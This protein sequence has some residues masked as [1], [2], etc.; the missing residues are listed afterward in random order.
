MAKALEPY[1]S[2]LTPLQEAALER[3]EYFTE[4]LRKMGIVPRTAIE[5]EMMVVD[6][7]GEPIPM[8]M[9]LEGIVDAKNK[10]SAITPNHIQNF[11]YERLLEDFE[12][13]N[14]VKYEANIIER[15]DINGRADVTGYSS[16]EVAAATEVL[17]RGGIAQMLK[18]T[19]C[20]S[21]PTDPHPSFKA[22][23]FLNHPSHHYDTCGLHI[24]M[25]LYDMDGDNLFSQSH[26]LLSHAAISLMQ[27]QNE[28]AFALLPNEN[29]I[30][31]IK[32]SYEHKDSSVAKRVG[33]VIDKPHKENARYASISIRNRLGYNTRIENRLPGADTDAFV[34]TA[35]TMA[36]LYDAVKKH[37]HKI[38]APTK[39]I[40]EDDTVPI[41]SNGS[42]Y[43]VDPV[44]T[45]YMNVMGRNIPVAR[46][47]L[48]SN[49]ERSAYA[50]ELLGNKLYKAIINDYR[51]QEQTQAV[52]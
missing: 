15:G 29:S 51:Q 50:R 12:P 3:I 40:L 34:A 48:L 21:S 8:A 46:H 11:G 32:T 45:E 36:A 47:K 41:K 9:R 30:Q 6:A 1:L 44:D 16:K 43:R 14:P 35:F 22:R 27:L 25:S 10:L 33:M 42:H 5:L 23:P 52:K 19:T 7:D 17:K 31:R 49:F 37:M 18:T 20:L 13:A 2:E 4:E 28:A 24:N 26:Q 39:I 38:E